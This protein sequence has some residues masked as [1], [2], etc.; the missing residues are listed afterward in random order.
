MNVRDTLY[1]GDKL[2]CQTKYAYVKGQKSRGLNTKPC[3]KPYTFDLKV[4]VQG[5]IRIMNV[6][7]TSSHGDRP[8]CQLWYANVLATCNRSYKPDMK[9]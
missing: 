9:T 6:L 5:R 7:D 1:Q 8:M 4:K 2:T 3:H